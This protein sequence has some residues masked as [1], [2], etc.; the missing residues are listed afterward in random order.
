MAETHGAV[1]Y[2]NQATIEEILKH[3]TIN[4]KVRSIESIVLTVE[5]DSGYFRKKFQIVLIVVILAQILIHL[6]VVVVIIKI[7]MIVLHMT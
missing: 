6:I 4:E 3:A 1:F 7:A 5:E 2:K